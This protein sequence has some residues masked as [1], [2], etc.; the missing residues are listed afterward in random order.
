MSEDSSSRSPKTLAD[1]SHL[2][3]SGGMQA[4]PEAAEARPDVESSSV[5]VVT[6]AD[7]GPG[8]ST[9]A[10]NLAQAMTGRG[11]TALYDADPR[12]PNA[13]FYLGLPSWN[14]LSPL[15][16]DG[17]PAPNTLAD[18]GLLI[19]DGA[20]DGAAFEGVAAE[21]PLV[22]VELASGE[23]YATDFVVVD[24]SL[25]AAARI[26]GGTALERHFIVVAR[27]GR[28]GFFE[29]YTA[30]A[31]LSRAGG[32]ASAGLVVNRVSSTSYARAFHAKM[33]VAAER[34]LSMKLVFLGGVIREPG[35]GALQR[36]RGAMVRSR[37]DA[38]SALLLREIASNALAMGEGSASSTGGSVSQ[39]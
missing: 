25:R 31:A 11:R 4:S 34:L 8:K 23:S 6:G 3:F 7:G 33:Q 5:F 12:V 1:V 22:R 39:A 14:Y 2:F 38:T 30:L 16:G 21:A 28:R 29:A 20:S 27:P 9:I 17:T 37:P 19:V 24:A 18:S 26:A 35:L 15:T 36:E 13:R 32:L 10:V